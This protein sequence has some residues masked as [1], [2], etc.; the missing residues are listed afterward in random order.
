VLAFEPNPS[1][2]AQLEQNVRLNGA[3]NVTIRDRA[4]AAE[5]GRATL[6]VPTT[7][8][9][10]FSSLAGGRFAE[11]EPVEVEVTTVDREVKKLELRPTV[12]K[13]DVEG[14]ELDVVAGMTETLREHRPVLL[15]EVS[16]ESARELASRLEG[17]SAFRVG[18][19]GLEPL[20]SGRGLFNA[21]FVPQPPV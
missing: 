5:H 18:R 15:V 11:G 16:E 17:Y 20:E 8:D 13:I 3:A 7:P 12:V 2:R 9:P 10:S 1:A 19:G 4:V 21:L 6:H 14:G